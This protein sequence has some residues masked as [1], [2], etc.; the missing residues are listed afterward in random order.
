MKTLII[1]LFLLLD[2][3]VAMAQIVTF[4]NTSSAFFSNQIFVDG[5][6]GSDITGNGTVNYPYLTITNAVQ[7]DITT[8]NNTN[9]IVIERGTFSGTQIICTNNSSFYIYSGVVFSAAY[10]S[11]NALTN[12]SVT[13]IGGAVFNGTYALT[14]GGTAC[15]NVVINL[16]STYAP[17]GFLGSANVID[18][19]G[20]GLEQQITINSYANI[21]TNTTF[22]LAN[23]SS[24]TNNSYI[25]ITGFNSTSAKFFSNAP[26]TI[27]YPYT[28]GC[29]IQLTFPSFAL[30]GNAGNTWNS[31]CRVILDPMIFSFA[32]APTATTTNEYLICRAVEFPTWPTNMVPNNIQTNATFSP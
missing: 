2:Q 28:G 25:H 17:I 20:A 29:T 16:G 13:I 12:T 8:F 5:V 26:N 7:Q 18:G 21:I 22:L 10:F 27:A 11:C 30:T 23:L 24:F 32:S 6:S 14:F 31:Y 1:L 3:L 9:T 19:G 15:S 4:A